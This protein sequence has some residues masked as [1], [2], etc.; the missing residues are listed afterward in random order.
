MPPVDPYAPVVDATASASPVVGLMDAATAKR[1]RDLQAWQQEQ[2]LRN[3]QEARTNQAAKLAAAHDTHLVA[4][5]QSQAN[6]RT[7]LGDIAVSQPSYGPRVRWDQ[8][9]PSTTQSLADRYGIENMGA[10]RDAWDKNIPP[11][12]RVIRGNAAKLG[13]QVAPDATDDEVQSQIA[14]EEQRR[15]QA[16]ATAAQAKA[17]GA[18]D[19]NDLATWRTIVRGNPTS[20][21]VARNLSTA[22]RNL[23]SINANLSGTPNAMSDNN[24]IAAFMGIE[25]PGVSPTDSDRRAATDTAGI[26]DKLK[27]HASNLANN[28]ALKLTPTQR[29]QMRVAANTA[30]EAY[31]QEYRKHAA[32]QI[33]EAIARGLDPNRVIAPGVYDPRTG[34]INVPQDP[35]AIFGEDYDQSAAPG[36]AGPPPAAIPSQPAN[37]SPAENPKAPQAPTVP[38]TA[39][40]HLQ[41][42]PELAPYFDQKYGRGSSAHYLTPATQ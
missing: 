18:Q 6:Q 10:A 20:Q 36:T 5:D 8:L 27:L 25:K 3:A 26:W 22:E 29:A 41:Q 32:S 17:G 1:Q 15:Q 19:K 4:Q 14:G 30:V 21:T 9:D 34:A 28:E 38:P 37:L 24:A 35:R 33:Q 11:Q 16:A 42:H 13:L 2:D 23:E 39:I 7:M 31:R 40:Q 12:N